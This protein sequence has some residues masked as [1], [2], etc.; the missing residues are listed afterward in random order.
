M[1]IAKIDL[2]SPVASAVAEKESTVTYRFHFT[3]L[4]T[5]SLQ[6]RNL[7]LRLVILT[8]ILFVVP[9]KLFKS[10]SAILFTQ[11]NDSCV[12]FIEALEWTSLK[13]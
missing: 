11:D 9:N 13:D 4:L 7:I 3:R 10:C 8:L 1:F 6:F 2:I 5:H 12:L